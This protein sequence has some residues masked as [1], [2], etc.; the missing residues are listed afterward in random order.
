MRKI[1]YGKRADL[2]PEQLEF[3]NNF[4]L[5][6]PPNW[7]HLA[8][9]AETN[10]SRR[11]VSARGLARRRA[12]QAHFLQLGVRPW[13]RTAE[14]AQGVGHRRSGF[15]IT[16]DA[17]ISPIL[18]TF[19]SAPKYMDSLLTINVII[20]KSSLPAAYFL[21]SDRKQVNYT[22]AFEAFF[23][24]PECQGIAPNSYLTGAKLI[25]AALSEEL[26]IDFELGL[27]NSLAAL[28]PDADQQFC[29]FHF[30]LTSQIFSKIISLHI[31]AKPCSPTCRSM[32]S[33]A[34]TTARR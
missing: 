4:L 5:L 31:L 34:S 27:A 29:H 26:V 20:G 1:E 25:L 15:L 22:R 19:F 3:V 32:A 23:A 10:H 9:T 33:F 11:P 17:L 28:F 18:G 30:R 13:N 2:K 24:L 16:R 8:G 7:D 12:R 6:Q 14:G 21:L